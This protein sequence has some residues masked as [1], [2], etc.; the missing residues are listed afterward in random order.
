MGGCGGGFGCVFVDV[1]VGVRCRWGSVCMPVGK[2]QRKS[3][4]H[5]LKF[6]DQSAS[7]CGAKPQGR[8]SQLLVGNHWPR[9]FLGVRLLSQPFP[10][11]LRSKS[12]AR[13]L[14]LRLR[15]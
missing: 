11:H 14:E 1:S 12:T 3:Q 6:V 4:P 15:E 7:L 5:R 9:R 13:K 10:V 8:V 2:D